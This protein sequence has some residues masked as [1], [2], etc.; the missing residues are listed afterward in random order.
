MKEHGSQVFNLAR[1]K[2]AHIQFRQQR[3]VREH[4][5]H[6]RD[7][8]SIQPLD[9]HFFQLLAIAEHLP[10][11]H[12]LRRI[13][14]AVQRNFLYCELLEQSGRILRSLNGFLRRDVQRLFGDP[15]LHGAVLRCG[16]IAPVC[17]YINLAHAHKRNFFHAVA[18][19]IVELAETLLVQHRLLP[20]LLLRPFRRLFRRRL[21]MRP[22][23]RSYAL[24][25][26][27]VGKALTVHPFFQRVQH[28]SLG[29]FQLALLHFGRKTLCPD[30]FQVRKRLFRPRDRPLPRARGRFVGAIERK[31]RLDCLSVHLRIPPGDLPNP[32]ARRGTGL[33]QLRVAR[34][35]RQLLRQC[36]QIRALLPDQKQPEIRL[37]GARICVQRLFKPPLRHC[38][39]AVLQLD[40]AAHH[41]RKRDLLLLLVNGRVRPL[42]EDRRAGHFVQADRFQMREIRRKLLRAH[43]RNSR[44]QE[45]PLVLAHQ[46]QEP[47]P[48]VFHPRGIHVFRAGR[49]HD[50]HPRGLQRRINIRFVFLARQRFQRRGGKEHAITAARKQVVEILSKRLSLRLV[51]KANENVKRPLGFDNLEVSPL[52]IVDFSSLAHVNFA[53]LCVR[54]LARR[55]IILVGQNRRALHAIDRRLV[56]A[57][58]LHVH[59]AETAQQQRPVRL[60]VVC[61]FIQYLVVNFHCAIEIAVLPVLIGALELTRAIRQRKPA[62][63]RLL[64]AAVIAQHNALRILHRQ[65]RMAIFTLKKHLHKN[66]PRPHCNMSLL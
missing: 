27:F 35:L 53:L 37:S 25:A 13:Q 44:N 48:F 33:P 1:V 60:G 11:A 16:N 52:D 22:I 15:C 38:P 31:Q 18:I 19:R 20:A 56:S 46:Q 24:A 5:K 36:V 17:G 2:S 62:R 55:A 66:R 45:P 63:Q 57:R 29:V 65:L 14:I 43:A 21:Q 51:L 28:P 50:H 7:I 23:G 4:A 61:I 8:S 64:R 34:R 47:L 12:R 54:M 10:H 59:H 26:R 49:D 39:V 40:I 6:I 32:F 58:I 9:V 42:Q 3:A 30:E 41:L